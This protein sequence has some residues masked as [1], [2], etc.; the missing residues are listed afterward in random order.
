MTNEID[1]DY[2][3]ANLYYDWDGEIA[4]LDGEILWNA[5]NDLSREIRNKIVDECLEVKRLIKR[6]PWWRRLFKMF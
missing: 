4:N 2:L 6:M 5:P 3:Q 1:R